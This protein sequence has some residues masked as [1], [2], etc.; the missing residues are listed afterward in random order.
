MAEGIVKTIRGGEHTYYLTN[1]M[2]H[3]SASTPKVKLEGT[4]ASAKNLSL[5]ENAGKID[6]YNEA[7][8]TVQE[9]LYPF[10]YIVANRIAAD[11]AAGDTW[12]RAVFYAK[13]AVTVIDAGIVPDAAFGQATNYAILTVKN[14]GTAGTGTTSIATKNFNAAVAAYDYT[15]LGTISNASVAADEVLTFAKTIGGTGQIVPASLLVLILE[16]AA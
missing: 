8:A 1:D 6:I 16:R 4:E 13:E 5:R 2:L 14:K 7:T 3:I 9:S 12:E 15:S 11:A 10:Y